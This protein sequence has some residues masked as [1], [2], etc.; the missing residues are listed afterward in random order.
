MVLSELVVVFRKL[1]CI[2][3]AH[4]NK[5]SISQSALLSKMQF[6]KQKHTLVTL[7]ESR[8]TFQAIC[9]SLAEV[10]FQRL[11]PS[12][13]CTPTTIQTMSCCSCISVSHSLKEANLDI[14][15]MLARH[16]R[17]ELS[18]P[19]ESRMPSKMLLN[20]SSSSK[21]NTLILFPLHRYLCLSLLQSVDPCFHS[22]A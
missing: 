19:S 21:R 8:L 17:T 15:Y 16:P 20:C 3:Q 2:P 13:S 4:H 7:W 22:N 12:V 9:V 10:S 18:F 14:S 11:P 1:T 5:Q 6:I